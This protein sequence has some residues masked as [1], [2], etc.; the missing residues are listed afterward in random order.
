VNF[1]ASG[2]TFSAPT[3]KVKYVAPKPTPTPVATE[4]PTPTAAALKKS[5]IT[6][7]KGKA[8]KKVTALKPVCPKGYKKK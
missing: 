6:C 7:I 8:V 4:S 2:F 3:I 5:T 1:V